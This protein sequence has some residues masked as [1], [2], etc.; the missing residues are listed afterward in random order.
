MRAGAGT[1][2]AGDA[3][4]CDNVTEAL[5]RLEDAA[6]TQLEERLVTAFVDGIETDLD[7]PLPVVQTTKK[8]IQ[9]ESM[10]RAKT[11]ARNLAEHGRSTF[12][13]VRSRAG[14]AL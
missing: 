11:I 3:N 8:N 14:M 9:Q 2:C 10:R 1:A 7:A 6:G 13:G 5:R 4:I 12:D